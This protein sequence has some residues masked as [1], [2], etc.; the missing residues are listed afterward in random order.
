MESEKANGYPATIAVDGQTSRGS[1]AQDVLPSARKADTPEAPD[2]HSTPMPA[3]PEEILSQFDFGLKNWLGRAADPEVIERLTLL[4]E[5]PLGRAQFNQ[6]LHLCHEPGIVDGFFKYYW[7]TA[8]I[9]TYDVTRVQ[10]CHPSWLEGDSIV[11]LEHLQWGLYRFCVDAL[12]YFGDIRIGF[13]ALRLMSEEDLKQFFATKRFNTDALKHRGPAMKMSLIAKDDRYLISE[14][15]C[16]SYATAPGTASELEKFLRDCYQDHHRSGGGKI[17]IRKLLELG[18]NRQ[19]LLE[20][21]GEFMFSADGIL[22]ETIEDEEQLNNQYASIV[23]SFQIARKA[24]LKNTKSFLSMAS[25]LDVY[26]ATSMRNREDF[27]KMGDFCEKVFR[28]PTLKS[29]N[30]R[31]FDPTMSAAEGHE[32]KGLIECLMVKCAKV[33]VY[34]AGK[35]DSFGKDVEAAM[36]LSQ[37]KPV[38]FYCDEE[39]RS[40]FFSEIHPLSRLIDFKTGVA[41]GAMVTCSQ[42]EVVDLLGRIFENRL[43][44]QLE[45]KANGALRLKEKITGSVIRVQTGDKLLRETFANYYHSS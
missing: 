4:N 7:L 22:D 30:L 43:E 42:P 6:L 28:D 32:D 1:R 27:R 9:H 15:A 11:S 44:Y 10:H 13:R 19:K 36:A 40:R 34:C 17:T 38:I 2:F 16:K 8:P 29:L 33:L 5:Q 14:M 31:Y 26:V 25:D 41:V 12:L 18:F 45:T 37:G 23:T 3:R 20:R 39:K 35:G 24:A 21:Q